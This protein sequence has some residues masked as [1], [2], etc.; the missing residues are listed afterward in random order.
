MPRNNQEFASEVKRWKDYLASPQSIPLDPNHTYNDENDIYERLTQH[1]KRFVEGEFGWYTKPSGTL[2]FLPENSI[3]KECEQLKTLIYHNMTVIDDEWFIAA[4]T[5]GRKFKAS[6]PTL[7]GNV[8]RQM[9][10]Q[11]RDSALN[12]LRVQVESTFF[13]AYRALSESFARRPFWQWFTRHSEYVAE[14]DALKVMKNLIKS[15]TLMNDKELN[16]ALVANQRRVTDEA[17]TNA[18]VGPIKLAHPVQAPEQKKGE[19]ASLGDNQNEKD[20]SAVQSDPSIVQEPKVIADSNDASEKAP[21][22]KNDAPSPVQK[23]KARNVADVKSKDY[24][25]VPYSHQSLSPMMFFDPNYIPNIYH[26][27]EERHFAEAWY[28]KVREAEQFK[29]KGFFERY[30]QRNT[31]IAKLSQALQKNPKAKFVF[32]ENYRR[33]NDVYDVKEEDRAQYVMDHEA[34]Y[35]AKADEVFAQ[36][37]KYRGLATIEGVVTEQDIQDVIEREKRA[38]QYKQQQHEEHEQMSELDMIKYNV[39]YELASEHPEILDPKTDPALVNRMIDEELHRRYPDEYPLDKV[40]F[41]GEFDE[42]KSV[43]TSPMIK[44]NE[45]DTKDLIP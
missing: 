17:V 3:T 19:G 30:S 14:R 38:E 12:S 36:N 8:V 4:K 25:F 23:P 35:R 10:K 42:D 34:E 43:P 33:V 13:P 2:E 37:P 26:I 22:Q 16:T 41:H 7:K 21:E 31:P 18:E 15:V 11:A 1:V 5:G 29:H 6:L 27:D 32:H 45:K 9:T 39:K 40:E 44:E 20:K 28:A 24:I